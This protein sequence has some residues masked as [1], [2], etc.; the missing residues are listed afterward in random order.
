VSYGE[1]RPAM[2]GEGDE[3]AAK[4]RRVELVYGAN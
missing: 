3:A 2:G 4:N 1:E